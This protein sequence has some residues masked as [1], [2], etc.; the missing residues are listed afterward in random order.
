M[1]VSRT[2][3]ST[4]S[5]L[6]VSRK[7]KKHAGTHSETRSGMGN[8]RENIWESAKEIGI[9]DTELRAYKH[10]A[11]DSILNKSTG[12]ERLSCWSAVETGMRAGA[13]C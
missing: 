12:A 6:S 11:V 8:M 10:A 1:I 7:T 5:K 9:S 2:N 13:L 3:P 4:M